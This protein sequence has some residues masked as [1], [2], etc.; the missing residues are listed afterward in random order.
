MN[1]TK[2][3]WL[4]LSAKYTEGICFKR[5]ESKLKD[6]LEVAEKERWDFEVWGD[7]GGKNG[8]KTQNAADDAGETV[9]RCLRMWRV[10]KWTVIEKLRC[11]KKG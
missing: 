6:N 4:H 8:Y 1:K 3:F 2:S 7:D 10:R 11:L 9:V 5:A